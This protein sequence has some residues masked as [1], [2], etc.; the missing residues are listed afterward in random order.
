MSEGWARPGS[1]YALRT[2]PPSRRLW[3]VIPWVLGKAPVP[4]V[5]WAHAVTAGKDPVMAF[6]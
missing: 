1:P 2:D 3:P 6:R 4:M 5:A